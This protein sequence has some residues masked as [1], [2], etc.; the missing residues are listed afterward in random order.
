MDTSRYRVGEVGE[1]AARRFV[2]GHHYSGSFPAAL[3]SYGLLDVADGRLVGVAVLGVPVSR[4]VL[5]NAFPSL[6]PYRESCELSRLVL[7]D[8]VPGNAESW[9][10]A[11]V[12]AQA[13]ERGI[14]GVVSF[15][16]PVP[17][18]TLAGEI[19]L[20]GHVGIVYQALG[21]VYAGRSTARTL[22]LL[23][24]GT[25]LN[26]RTV[27]K[28]RRQEQGH[29]YAEARLVAAGAAPLRPGQD[30]VVWLGRA[31]ADVG[32]RLLRHGG[33]HRYLFPI[34]TP[35]D[36]RAVRR[37]LNVTGPYPKQVDRD[38]LDVEVAA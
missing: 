4:P 5:T 6:E 34:G 31:F 1:V 15:S 30:P 25:V 24:D 8:E 13:R 18:T 38:G 20:P 21:A 23:P 35:A 7:L 2:E 32:V 33:A 26:D 37:S 9:F 3:V 28:I 14:R 12:F 27:Q 11:R 36:R 16:D 19:I 22:R 17:R 29:R 10:V